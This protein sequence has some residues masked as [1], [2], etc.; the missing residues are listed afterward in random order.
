MIFISEIHDK[1]VIDSAYDFNRIFRNVIASNNKSLVERM[2]SGV[3]INGC[4]LIFVMIRRFDTCGDDRFFK[5]SFVKTAVLRDRMQK[6][7]V[8]RKRFQ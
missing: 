5:N 7:S 8:C 6:I 3:L 2:G 4:G 1:F